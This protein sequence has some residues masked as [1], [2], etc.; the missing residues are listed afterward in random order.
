MR[1]EGKTNVVGWPEGSK[2]HKPLD[3]SG[4]FHRTSLSV[5]VLKVFLQNSC[6]HFIQYFLPLRSFLEQHPRT[7][8]TPEGRLEAKHQSVPNELQGG[9]TA[10]KGIP[11]SSKHYALLSLR[12]LTTN[13]NSQST[14]WMRWDES[15]TWGCTWP[16]HVVKWPCERTLN[17]QANTLG[18]DC[19]C[20]TDFRSTAHLEQDKWL[21][22]P[23]G[24]HQGRDC[25]FSI[26]P[27]VWHVSSAGT[28]PC[29]TCWG[30]TS[31]NTS[32]N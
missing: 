7:H 18:C 10:K 11:G 5:H 9:G 3:E 12:G 20:R 23:W 24:A 22:L 21:F 16:A 30:R 31:L 26:G 19:P 29:L 4:N 15:L 14:S 25:V 13:S 28:W 1:W 27:K 17:S 6:F 2:K 8:N 32:C